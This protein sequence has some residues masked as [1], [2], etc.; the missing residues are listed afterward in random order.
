M[1]PT[2][3]W[4]RE[5]RI[6]NHPPR[7]VPA[8][9]EEAKRV[10]SDRD[11]VLQGL[12]EAY[13]DPPLRSR[14]DIFQ[15]L[16]HSIVGQQISVAAAESIWKRLVALVGTIEPDEILARTEDE[17]RSVGLSGRKASYIRGLADEGRWVITHGWEKE[18]DAEVARQ[19]CT[20]R[21][22]GPW[23]ADMILLFVLL[24][25]DVL[26]LGDVALVRA[27]QERYADGNKLS[28]AALE[29]LGKRWAPYRTVA[30]WYLWRGLD[31]EPIEY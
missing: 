29:K 2:D 19:L 7:V 12:I 17:L 16:V 24:R 5:G 31:P 20:L 13:P 22:I 3:D 11:P 15:T 14:G 21:G 30:T 1:S 27:M 18:S 6:A 10:L 26:P 28:K 8:Y 9:W 4:H 25:P 23:T